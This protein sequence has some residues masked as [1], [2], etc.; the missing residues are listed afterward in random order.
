MKINQKINFVEGQFDTN[1][2]RMICIPDK[3]YGSVDLCLKP[4]NCMSITIAKIKLYSGNLAVNA[5]A[6]FEGAS[7]LGDEIA[8]CWNYVQDY[9]EKISGN[10]VED[11]PNGLLSLEPEKGSQRDL[12]EKALSHLSKTKL[13]DS[14]IIS[15]VIKLSV[16]IKAAELIE[17]GS[18]NV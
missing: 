4:K 11:K 1:S 7:I 3:K 13:V 14:E 16:F 8:K 12:Y 2:D 18:D 9:A 6:V 17:G 5:D 15:N 10:K